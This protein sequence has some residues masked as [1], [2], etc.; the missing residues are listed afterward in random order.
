MPESELQIR[1]PYSAWGEGDEWHDKHEELLGDLDEALEES[2]AGDGDDPDHWEEFI[3][4][5]AIGE[6]VE[7]LVAAVRPV[8]EAHGVL[9]KATG[10]VTD[11]DA[12][13]FEVG[14]VVAL[15]H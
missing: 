13:D 7:A 3:V 6:D 4:F 2:G 8:L 14:T 9:D 12:E 1:L 15:T 10:F 5:Y 11:P